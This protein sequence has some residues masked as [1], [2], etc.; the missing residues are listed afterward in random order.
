MEQ[1]L[2][3]KEKEKIGYMINYIENKSYYRFEDIYMEIG[4]HEDLGDPDAP[5]HKWYIRM[6]YETTGGEMEH[7]KMNINKLSHVL[8]NLVY[9]SSKV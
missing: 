5:H 7:K 6:G 1:L 9:K 4:K 2:K 3:D 8:T